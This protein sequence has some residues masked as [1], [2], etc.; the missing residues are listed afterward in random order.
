M[1]GRVRVDI[2]DHEIE[3]TPVYDPHFLVIVLLLDGAKETLPRVLRPQV[4]HPPWSV[5][6]L[7]I[8]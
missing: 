2:D 8:D 1:A 4:N 5:N 3:I 6:A 7:Q